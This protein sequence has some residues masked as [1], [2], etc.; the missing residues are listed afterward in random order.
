[1]ALALLKSGH[2]SK[3]QRGLCSEQQEA[4][5]LQSTCALS[6]AMPTLPCCRSTDTAGACQSCA[7][8]IQLA[9]VHTAHRHLHCWGREVY[10]QHHHCN[11]SKAAAHLSFTVPV[12]HAGQLHARSFADA[13]VRT[14]RMGGQHALRPTDRGRHRFT[15]ANTERGADSPERGRAL[16][17]SW[18]AQHGEKPDVYVE[19]GGERHKF[20]RLCLLVSCVLSYVYI[21]IIYIY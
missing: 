21:C 19:E 10:S 2:S 14:Q 17:F 11:V 18:R 8:A 3:Y 12:A 16:A 9:C 20:E 4:T 1:M 6:C 5:V 7:D 15:T 13:E